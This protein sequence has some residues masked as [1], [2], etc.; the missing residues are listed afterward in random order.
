MVG[1][2]HFDVLGSVAFG[3]GTTSAGSI[4]EIVSREGNTSNVFDTTF[5]FLPVDGGGNAAATFTFNNVNPGVYSVQFHVR[6]G[7]APGCPSTNCNAI[8]RSGGAFAGELVRF[9]VPGAIA[10]WSGDGDLEDEVGTND[11]ATIGTVNYRAAQFRQGFDLDGSGY[12]QVAS[13]GTSG[14]AP[15]SGFT[16]AMW[17][18]QDVFSNAASV[19]NLRTAANSSGFTLEPAFNVPG[20]FLLAVNTDGTPSGFSSLIPGGFPFGRWFW[21]AAT[22]DAAT[23][24]MRVYRD[25]LVVAERS[26]VPGTNMALTGSE[27]LAIGHNIV[28]GGNFDGGLDD[29]LY[30]DY[31][32]AQAEL[33][34]ILGDRVFRDG[35]E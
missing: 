30:F 26:D 4:P 23:H 11:I 25:G 2:H 33:L 35:F 28:N 5:G 17:V 31:A 20:N 15:A 8:Y 24:T 16:V 6:E 10:F 18:N 29:V 21:I 12:L 27:L 13:P 7:G 14:L 9:A 22:F 3:G 1:F 32:L 34:E 19:F